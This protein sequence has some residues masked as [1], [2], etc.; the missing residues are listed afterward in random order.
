MGPEILAR[1]GEVRDARVLIANDGLVLELSLPAGALPARVQAGSDQ[2]IW[3][4]IF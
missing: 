2:R 3:F 4:Q 1:A